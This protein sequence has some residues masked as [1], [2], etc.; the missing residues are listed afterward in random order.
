M[1]LLD[2]LVCDDIR[3]EIGQ[4]TTLVGIYRDLVISFV[5]E[6]KWPFVIRLCFYLRFKRAEMDSMPDGFIVDF[7]LNENKFHTLDG[8]LGISPDAEVDYFDLMLVNNAFLIPGDG[9]ITFLVKFLKN[10]H[11]IQ[12]IEPEYILNVRCVILS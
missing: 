3:Q 7:L 10:E 6:A 9:K 5:K 2:F 12:E 8:T 1:K 11:V 4:K